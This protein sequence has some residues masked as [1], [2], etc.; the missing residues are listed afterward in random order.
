M[1]HLVRDPEIDPGVE[2]EASC[3]VLNPGVVGFDA[4]KSQLKSKDQ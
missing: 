3:G 1:L 2:M 4:K